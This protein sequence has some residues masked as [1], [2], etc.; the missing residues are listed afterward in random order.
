LVATTVVFSVIYVA[1]GQ[2]LPL[3][4]LGLLL[5]YFGLIGLA[6][7]VLDITGWAEDLMSYHELGLGFRCGGTWH[8]VRFDELESF[9]ASYTD[10]FVH[11]IYLCRSLVFRFGFTTQDGSRRS[12]RFD[13]GMTSRDGEKLDQL[14]ERA[15]DAV[16]KRLEAQLQRGEE[17]AWTPRIRITKEGLHTSHFFWSGERTDAFHEISFRVEEGWMR[18]SAD[19][20]RLASV[21]SDVKNFFP[22]RQ[23]LEWH[24]APPS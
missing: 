8:A 24:G 20:E 22:I 7:V 14:H 21:R 1:V 11:G 5:V 15:T 13:N 3:N 23:L 6:G 9:T 17:I 16:A 4:W 2:F 18:L 10:R 19:N 12:F